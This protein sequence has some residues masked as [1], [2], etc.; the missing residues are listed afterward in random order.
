MTAVSA[1]E[2][3]A[4]DLGVIVGDLS[5][6]LGHLVGKRLLVTGGAGFLGYYFVQAVLR[7]NEDGSREPIRV[8]TE[9]TPCPPSSDRAREYAMGRSPAR[10]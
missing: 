4:E 6:E 8:H 5:D 3:V 2:I 9:L 10:R 7:A 1:S